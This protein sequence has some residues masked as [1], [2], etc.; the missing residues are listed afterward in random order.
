MI[1]FSVVIF[2][3][4]YES[5]NFGSK[6]QVTSVQPINHTFSMS[7]IFN[8]NMSLSTSSW[9]EIRGYECKKGV[10]LLASA[11]GC[12]LRPYTIVC[13]TRAAPQLVV[14][15]PRGRAPSVPNSEI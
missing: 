6:H 5:L 7:Y 1:F 14:G 13:I 11:S 10:A 2:Y 8:Y 3:F 9:L 15:A 4:V 12:V